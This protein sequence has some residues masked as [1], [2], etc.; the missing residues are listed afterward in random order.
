MLL[1]VW[2]D[3]FG[4]WRWRLRNEGAFLAYSAT[5]DKSREDALQSAE[6]ALELTERDISVVFHAASDH[7]DSG[8]T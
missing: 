2:E 7:I 4:I 8:V 3:R 6:V 5:M 1:E